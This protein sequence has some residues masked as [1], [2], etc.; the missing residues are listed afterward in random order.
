MEGIVMKK[1]SLRSAVAACLLALLCLP[2]GS[3]F[4]QQADI[5]AVQLVQPAELVKMMRASGGDKP[6]V[7]QVD[8]HVLYMQAH[9]PG[10]EYVG[11]G[12]HP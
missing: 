5:L 2:C 4:A 10:S 12:G 3:A 6:L 11:A 8:W 9:V 1:H 7:L